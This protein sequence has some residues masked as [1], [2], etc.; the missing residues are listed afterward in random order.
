MT[1]VAFTWKNGSAKMKSRFAVVRPE[2][3]LPW[4]GTSMG[5]KAVHRHVLQEL[6]NGRTLLRTEESM[7]G[8]LLTAFFSAAK[9]RSS[10]S[11]WA[12]SMKSA[13]EEL[14]SASSGIRKGSA[15]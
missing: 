3:E 15:G 6:D 7:S 11:T 1:V 10:L 8:L 4:T 14:R 5:F 13:A 9:L 2:V 12:D